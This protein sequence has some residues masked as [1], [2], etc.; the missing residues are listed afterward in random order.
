MEF[1]TKY[2]NQAKELEELRKKED[3]KENE[4][5]KLNGRVQEM[6]VTVGLMRP[7]LRQIVKE[8]KTEGF[9]FTD[10]RGN[11]IATVMMKNLHTNFL[12]I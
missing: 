11:E 5:K 9:T 1:E 2:A 6:E 4:I 3:E 12:Y 10:S 7:L 8:T